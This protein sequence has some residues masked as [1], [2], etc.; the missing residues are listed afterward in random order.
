MQNPSEERSESTGTPD[1]PRTQP[2]SS[3]QP[4]NPPA[5]A[6]SDT[7]LLPFPIVGIG[8]SAGGLEAFEKF[9]RHM[10]SDMGIAFVIV[11]HLDPNHDS[12]LVDIVRRYTRMDVLQVQDGMQVQPDT[13]Y[14]IPPNRDMSLLHRTLYLSEP[15]AAR[16][17]RLPI[18][19][20]FRSLAEDLHEQAIC[21]ILSGTGTDGTLGMRA[22]KGEGGMAMVQTPSSAKYDGMPQNAIATGMV[23]YTL[24]PE[25]MPRQ[26]STY[27]RQE[28]VP[29]K[30]RVEPA[31]APSSDA[32]QKVF[33]SLRSQTGHDF[34]QYKPSTIM[35]RIERRMTVNQMPQIDDYVSFLRQSP[36]E[37]DTLFREMLIG[38]TSFFRDPDAFDALQH[39]VLPYL[40]Q[41]RPRGKPVRVWV[42]GCSTGEEAYSLA[43]L[44]REYANQM[45]LD[46]TVQLF[47]TDIDNL[48]IE[49][50][51]AGIYPDSIAA[52]VSAER[53]RQFFSHEG[54]SFHVV[55]SVREMVIFAVQNVIKDPPFSTIDLISCRNLLIYMNSD[56][57]KR[58]LPLF[59]YALKP[60][61]FLFLGTSETPGESTRLFTTI[62]RKWSL[63]QRMEGDER[64]KMP[65]GFALPDQSRSLWND[66]QTSPKRSLREIAERTLLEQYAPPGVIINEQGDILYFHGKT[67]KYLEPASGDASLNVYEMAREGL[68][69]VLP[70][71]VRDSI[72]RQ[73]TTVHTGIQVK[74]NRAIQVIN[75]HITPLPQ[76]L[77]MITFEEVTVLEPTALDET[78]ADDNGEQDQ[79]VHALQQELNSTREYLQ[80]TIEELQSSNEEVKSSN[81]ELQSTNE[82]LQSTNEELV[83]SKEELQSVNEE[84]VTVNTE[85]RTKIDQ[86]SRANNDQKN[87]LASMEVGTIFLDHE[88]HILR[89][90]PAAEKVLNV[91]ESD[92]GRPLGHLTSTIVTLNLVEI[93]EGVL[94]DLQIR[95]EEVQN[96]DG[97]WFM[98]R[99]Q[100]YRTTE[101]VV[102]GVVI[103]FSDIT[104]QKRVQEDLYNHQQIIEGVYSILDIPIFVL[105]MRDDGD[106]Y[107]Q[108]LNPAN[109]RLTGYSRDMVIGKRNQDLDPP[110]DPA[111]IEEARNYYRQCVERGASLSY[112]QRMDTQNR[113]QW[114]SVQLKPLKDDQGEVYRIVGAAQMITKQ[115][116]LQTSLHRFDDLVAQLPHW[117]Q[118]L[119]HQHDEVALATAFS[120]LLVQIE[121]YQLVRVGLNVP[122]QPVYSIAE[123]VEQRSA[124]LPAMDD[125]AL[126][127][128][129]AQQLVDSVLHAG[130]FIVIADIVSDSAYASWHATCQTCSIASVM[131]V[132]LVCQGQP[133]GAVIVGASSNNFF[134]SVTTSI[135]HHF[136]DTLAYGLAV[137]RGLL[138][139]KED[140]MTGGTHE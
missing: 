132:P 74:T 109:E 33:L 44:F 34:S 129:V 75:V 123:W 40:F 100:P 96:Q 45:S 119:H 76:S 134:D 20:F 64:T 133:L 67:G 104:R 140:T 24:P 14:I 10:A 1:I 112:E 103:T 37:I 12:M 111:Q 26:L 108:D 30:R 85:L 124:Q 54:N 2:E 61:G 137:R 11:Q 91:L 118:T 39:K 5:Q 51:R 53:L 116:H 89:F 101:N 23:D 120:H 17:L 87:L 92:I 71:A 69:M 80:T 136:I 82:E 63:F 43:I 73:S 72:K 131:V 15:E 16:G 55:Q 36:V 70:T 13:I 59:H 126:D 99:A 121:G 125:V 93:A 56:L 127:D 114:W 6:A 9:F 48:A 105:D 102:E 138:P 110:L 42:P 95:E 90:T 97:E 22:I 94:H 57:Q 28:F 46:Y 21:I 47:A 31:L 117:H 130:E 3:A 62:D 107:Y 115:K 65:P 122:D 81:E 38:V 86:L 135:L 58:V 8:A 52:D 84:L 113:E 66:P 27:V 139:I 60:G 7:S 88:L 32:L 50:A 78:E 98:L 19:F 35:R 49:K 4:D 41:E 106:F 68:N 18:D 25:D 83:T 29:G 77:L 128:G 79:R